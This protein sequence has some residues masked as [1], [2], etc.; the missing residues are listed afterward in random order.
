MRYFFWSLIEPD[1]TRRSTAT[2]RAYRMLTRQCITRKAS[3]T[4]ALRELLEGALFLY[5]NL[6][7]AHNEYDH[8]A[9]TRTA[10]VR[11]DGELLLKLNQKHGNAPH[12][13]RSILHAGI[14]GHGPKAPTR[15]ASRPDRQ[16]QDLY[17]AALAACCRCDDQTRTIDG[18]ATVSLLLVELVSTD[19][20]YN[21]L[22][23]PDEEQLNKVTM[24]RDLQ[25]RRTFRNAPILWA[26]LG[27][28][29]AHR[30]AIC[31]ASVLLRALC[32]SALYQWRSKSVDKFQVTD[33][34]SELFA[35]TQ[36]T[37]Q[38]MSMGQLLPAPLNVLHTLIEHLEPVEI[39]IVLKEC[40]WNYM[41][42]H[43]P[44]PVLYGVDGTG[45]HWRDPATAKPPM[46]YLDPLRHIMQC[47]L[48]VLGTFYH[49]M[50]VMAE[51]SENLPKV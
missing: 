13:V 34:E 2:D 36:R 19:V 21:G 38:L 44:A 24:E 30:P 32:A 1:A 15:H 51:L 18:Y 16:L 42:E 9:A 28:V 20:M 29:A 26:I 35:V 10:S 43:V 17:L 6:F 45:L 31:Y 8:E 5:G 33:V 50:F 12:A 7:G 22:P 46:H 49:Q 39:A 47:K 25:I 3:R 41:R 14:I 40:V 37:L 11:G 48:P 27:L 23:W 4:V